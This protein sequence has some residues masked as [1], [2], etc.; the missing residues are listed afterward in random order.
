MPDTS[1]TIASPNE[2]S[3]ATVGTE[4]PTFRLSAAPVV[5]HAGDAAARY[6]E[7]GLPRTYGTQTLCLMARDPHTIFAYWDIDWQNAFA[8]GTPRDRK[9]NLRLLTEDGS[10]QSLVEVEPMAGSCEIS[11]PDADTAYSGELGYFHPAK[12]WNSL[13]TSELIRTPP[14]ALAEEGEIDFATVPFHLAFQHMID[15]LRISKQESASLTGMLS[16][17]RERASSIAAGD[18]LTSQQRELAE[19][20]EGVAATSSAALDDRKAQ[21]WSR[22]KLERILGFGSGPSSPANGFGGSSRTH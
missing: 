11:V 16:D 3:S 17:L 1:D 5:E 6:E 13:A 18:S 2:S 4:S 20:I 15:L 12:T 14:D 9:V 22:Q 21:T 10:E 19:V 8:S 7:S